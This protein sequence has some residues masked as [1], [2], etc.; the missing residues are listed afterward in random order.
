[1][2]LLI[3]VIVILAFMASLVSGI[4][5][6]FVRSVIRIIIVTSAIVGAIIYSPDCAEYLNNK[7]I[8][9]P[10]INI[11]HDSISKL[12]SDSVDI[13]M[14]ADEKPNA[15]LKA[16]NRFGVEVDDIKAFIAANGYT[17]EE[18]V[19]KIAEYMGAPVAAA[20]SKVIAFIL[21]FIGLWFILWIIG[22]LICLIVTLPVLRTADKLLG[23]VFGTLSGLA[24]AW[25]LSIALCDLM[26]HLAVIFEGSISDT[27][28]DN[29]VIVK[30]LGSI[31]PF[32][33][34]SN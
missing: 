33:L 17:D 13:D 6:G 11:A 22:K 20:L 21:L 19:D 32:S 8:E 9:K 30:Y 29:S 12:T 27:I 15:F 1:M 18:K 2:S 31:D 28:V 4:K 5:K 34:F 25:G 10:V 7:Y 16:L 26:P 3:D 14:L 23:C 24:F